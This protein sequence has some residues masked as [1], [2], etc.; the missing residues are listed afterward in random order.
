MFVFALESFKKLVL[1]SDVKEKALKHPD[2][3][4]SWLGDDVQTEKEGVSV[5]WKDR[6]YKLS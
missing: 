6:S 3:E 1:E 5:P 4:G 2:Y